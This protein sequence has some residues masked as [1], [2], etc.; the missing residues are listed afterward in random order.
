MLSHR[1]ISISKF[2]MV[3][4]LVTLKERPRLLSLAF[5]PRLVLLCQLF[6]LIHLMADGYCKM[7][8][9]LLGFYIL[10]SYWVLYKAFHWFM[11]LPCEQLHNLHFV[12]GLKLNSESREWGDRLRSCEKDPCWLNF[13]LTDRLELRS[14]RLREDSWQNLDILRAVDM[15]LYRNWWLIFFTRVTP[16]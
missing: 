15:Y 12:G 8:V 16:C 5:W 6:L 9:D 1:I 10:N 14:P 2:I 4:W 11:E 3:E 13:H 7:V